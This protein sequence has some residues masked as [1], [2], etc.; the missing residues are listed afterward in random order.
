MGG[1]P[2]R[3]AR[4]DKARRKESGRCFWCV[5]AA[6][7]VEFGGVWWSSVGGRFARRRLDAGWYGRRC[8]WR[9]P[10]WEGR[11]SDSRELMAPAAADVGGILAFLGCGSVRGSLCCSWVQW[12]SQCQPGLKTQPLQPCSKPMVFAKKANRQKNQ[13]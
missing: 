13:C 10:G 4:P 7:L 6:E 12:P 2:W 5:W 11:A 3:G 9:E 8:S 1:W